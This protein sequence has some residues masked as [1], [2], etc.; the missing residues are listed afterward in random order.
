LPFVEYAVQGFVDGLDE[1]LAIVNQEQI[2]VVWRNFVHE[3][4]KD[5]RTEALVRRRRLVLDLSR[6]DR[7]V[8]KAEIPYLTPRLARAYAGKGPKTVPRDLNAL[9]DL[10]LIRLTKRGVVAKKEL[11]LSF[12]PESVDE[13]ADPMPDS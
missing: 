7:P 9:A 5:K 12:V 4:F 1:Q 10:G 3:Q 6:M 2:D 11:V 13:P 8:P